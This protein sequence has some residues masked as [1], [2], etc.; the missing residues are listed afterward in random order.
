[1][2]AIDQ[3]MAPSQAHTRTPKRAN[4]NPKPAQVHAEHHGGISPPQNPP[5]A[6]SQR[7]KSAQGAS[8]SSLG[9]RRQALLADLTPTAAARSP[10]LCWRPEVLL[11]GISKH[12]RE[13]IYAEFQRLGGIRG[14][15]N[16]HTRA[17]LSEAIYAVEDDLEYR[18]PDDP[19]VRAMRRVRNWL[20]D[21]LGWNEYPPGRTSQD[22]PPCRKQ[23]R[24]PDPA[25]GGA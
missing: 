3:Q 9:E 21:D 19:Q 11:A 8:T 7:P 24:A 17:L 23:K 2:P 25:S 6:P 5:R 10:R 22:M 12:S 16:D 14:K 15:L 4:P 20:Y 13:Q 1:M 18:K